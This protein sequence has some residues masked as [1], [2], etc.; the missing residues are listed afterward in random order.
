VSRLVGS[1]GLLS[2]A[3]AEPQFA[4][5]GVLATGSPSI[6]FD[7]KP[8]DADN[9]ELFDNFGTGTATFQTNKT[10]LSVTAGQWSVR[11]SRRVMPYFSGYPAIIEM[12][13][14]N[15]HSEPGV[16]KRMGYFSTSE[17]S[18]YT[19]GADGFFIED[20]G[21][22]KFLCVYRNGTE[23]F[24]VPEEQWIGARG[25]TVRCENVAEDYDW[26]K[27]TVIMFD[28]LWLG[29]AAL[30]VWLRLGDRWQLLHQLAMVGTFS[31]VIF[32]SPQHRIRYEI[33]SGSGAGTFRA[34]CS[35]FSVLGDV[36]DKGFL[37]ALYT[38][39]DVTCS[40]SGVS[41]ALIGVKLNS[42][43]PNLAAE[44]ERIGMVLTNRDETGLLTLHKNPTL[45][46]ALSYSG[47]VAP[48]RIDVAFGSGETVVAPI[49]TILAVP[50]GVAS[51]ASIPGNYRRWLGRG[52]DG[53]EDEY[54]L[55]YTPFS[56][57]QQVRGI[58]ELKEHG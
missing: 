2:A 42:T 26:S 39:S 9:R 14:D 3:N 32:K 50:A 51:Q 21:T 24:R 37:D 15:F 41:Y 4:G 30:R 19:A 10:Q 38:P 25:R 11:A 57:N 56:A 23:I 1:Y 20:D 12:T 27:F 55:C 29:G 17:T 18:P 49:E 31:D 5:S 34:I 45:S 36:A 58:L 35:Q 46:A 28:F 54:V 13:A 7:G 40:T 48:Q 22:G 52:V 33:R 43:Y 6:I 44:V 8:L 16:V 53:V 47:P